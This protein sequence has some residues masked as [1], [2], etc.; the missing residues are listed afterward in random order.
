MPRETPGQRGE[1]AQIRQADRPART[2][3]EAD[4]RRARRRIADHPQRTDHVDHLGGGE[5]SA[6]A[7]DAVR[8]AAAPECVTE[9]DHVL[10]AAEEDGPRRRAPLLRALCPHPGEPLGH[11]IGLGIEVGIEPEL[12]DARRCAGARAQLLHGHRA[13]GCRERREHGVR[14]GQHRGAVA[15]AREQRVLRAV[16]ARGEG[17]GETAEIAG[18][19]AAPAVDRLMRIADGHHAG[20]REERGEQVGL[21]HRGVLVL[22]EEHHAVSIAQLVGHRGVTRDHLEGAGDLVGEVDDPE[23]QLL[24]GVLAGEVGQ[25]GESIDPVD[26]V[27]DIR[28]DGRPPVGRRAAPGRRGSARGT[29]RARRSRRGCRR[30]RGR[31]AAPRRRWSARLRRAPRGADRRRRRRR[32]A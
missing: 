20:A 19:R 28:I 24:G 32:G 29:P 31:C 10:L 3:Q 23:P 14:R 25:E 13:R 27:G 8:D 7:E 22:V 17:V 5:Q 30:R 21:R 12:D 4:E 15:P 6:E 11:T 9:A 16:R 2:R 1:L 18:A 26:R